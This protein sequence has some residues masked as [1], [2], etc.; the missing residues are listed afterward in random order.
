MNVPESCFI[1]YPQ[2]RKDIGGLMDAKI[3][4]YTGEN[5]YSW[6]REKTSLA[7]YFI[8]IGN[9]ASCIPGGFWAPIEKA[10]TVKGK[11]IMPDTLSRLASKK[12]NNAKHPES[13]DFKDIK[14]TVIEYREVYKK[15]ESAKSILYEMNCYLNDALK[16]NSDTFPEIFKNVKEHLRKIEHIFS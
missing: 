5:N 8:W 9:N 16:Y 13:N 15:Y 11:P 14:K 1:Y 6:E 2:F 12:R 4:K 3:L 7:L 10:F